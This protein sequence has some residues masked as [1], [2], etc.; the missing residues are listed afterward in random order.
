[1][2]LTIPTELSEITILQYQKWQTA[3]KE[4]QEETFAH[5]AL[6]SIFCN[7]PA[8][9]ALTIPVSELK[10][11]AEIIATTLNKTPRFIQ[12]FTMDGIEYGFIPNLD[13]MT[14]SEYIDLD[15]YISD[16]ES[17]ANSMAVM[18]RKIT[19]KSFNL[20][21]IED[22]NDTGDARPERVQLMLN[23]PLEVYLGAKVFFYTLSNELLKST[24]HFIQQPTKE[25][26]EMR[27]VLLKSGVGI[28]QY[29]QSL[30]DTLKISKKSFV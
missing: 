28:N 25:A 29:I 7:I 13:K 15:T 30:T 10:E 20:Y 12:R 17:I 9:D 24:L 4:S 16:D 2:K 21:R 1:M 18:F 23:A 3:M 8:R 14:A 5:L 26:E 11:T 6:V 22:Y 27:A 19:D